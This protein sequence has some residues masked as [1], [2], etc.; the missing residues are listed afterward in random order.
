M[1][2]TEPEREPAGLPPVLSE[3]LAPDPGEDVRDRAWHA[4]LEQHDRLLRHICRS[5]GGDSDAEM[6]RYARVLE[7]LR[8]DDFR[9]LRRFA[10]DGRGRFTTWLTVVTRRICL[11]HER[12]RYGRASPTSDA[13]TRSARRRLADLVAA[14][15]DPDRLGA[16]APDHPVARLEWEEVRA[17]LHRATAGLDPEDRLLL[18]LRF[19]D[20]L[21]AREIAEVVGF[22]TPFH[23]YRRLNAILARLKEVLA[24][25]G[26][27]EAP[28]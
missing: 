18:A 10:A 5:L 3:L 8:T 9:R 15:L 26:I 17:A 21:S 27:E 20:D 25:H 7:E 28:A 12:S 23:V 6:D 13:D 19:A 4:F 22:P 14:N 24:E 11:D 1:V 16:P 2:S